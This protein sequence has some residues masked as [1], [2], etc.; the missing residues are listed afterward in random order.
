MEG[1]EALARKKKERRKSNIERK[2]CNEMEFGPSD[3]KGWLYSSILL[4]FR[5]RKEK[6]VCFLI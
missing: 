6:S 5:N 3:G 4:I 1:G 2:I